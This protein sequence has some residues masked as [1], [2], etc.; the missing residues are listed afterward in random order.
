MTYIAADQAPVYTQVPNVTFTGLAAP[1]RG[2][3]DTAVW[4]V[5][6]APGT[7]GA[8]HRLTREEIIVA[9]AGEA[10]A[11]LGGVTHRLAAGGAL[12]VPP[13]T[14]FALANP[15]GAPFRAVAVLPVGGQACMPG[16]EPFTPPWAA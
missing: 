3:R 7:P 1:S 2:A 11:T 10:V 5:E 6:I 13:D 8:T 9:I 4:L 12:V 14:D 15:G 16:G